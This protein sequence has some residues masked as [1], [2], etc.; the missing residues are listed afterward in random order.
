MFGLVI[1]TFQVD[2]LFSVDY[3]MKPK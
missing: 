2:E 1:Q 3:Q